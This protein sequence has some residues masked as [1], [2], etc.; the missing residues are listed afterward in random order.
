[1]TDATVRTVHLTEEEVE[2]AETF[3][4][5]FIEAGRQSGLRDIYLVALI[6]GELGDM[7]AFY[8]T[9]HGDDPRSYLATLVAEFQRGY[10]TGMLDYAK[11]PPRRKTEIN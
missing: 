5:A 1:M 8:H 4:T 11:N 2:K 7:A 10:A 6:A 9:L 3:I